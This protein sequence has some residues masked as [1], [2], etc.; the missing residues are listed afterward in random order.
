[1]T[2]AGRSMSNRW[3]SRMNGVIAAPEMMAAAAADLGSIGSTISAANAAVAGPTTQVLASGADE[4]SVAVATLFGAHAQAYQAISAQAAA[5][6]EQLVQR[7]NAGAVSYGN[8]EAANANPLQ[9]L[10]NQV[11][12]PVE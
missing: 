10:L 4:V 1:M 3:D 8:A 7:L 12:A 11:N 5:F 2:S 9:G 6:H